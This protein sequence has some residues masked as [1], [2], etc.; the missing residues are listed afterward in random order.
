[1][2]TDSS[3]RPA[4]IKLPADGPKFPFLVTDESVQSSS[5]I[6]IGLADRFP[7]E[8]EMTNGETQLF[9][10]AGGEITKRDRGGSAPEYVV[11]Q[12]HSFARDDENDRSYVSNFH[13]KSLQL[14]SAYG[15]TMVYSAWLTKAQF[16]PEGFQMA[17]YDEFNPF[18]GAVKMNDENDHYAN[19]G[20]P[21]TP[22]QVRFENLTFPIEVEVTLHYNL[23]DADAKLTEHVAACHAARVV[24]EQ[25]A[26]KRAAEVERKRAARLEARKAYLLT[27]E[28][29]AETAETELL[30]TVRAIPEGDSWTK[31]SLAV[32]RGEAAE[33]VAK[34]SDGV[35][36]ELKSERA[37][38]TWGIN[39]SNTGRVAYKNAFVEAVDNR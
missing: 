6:T 7:E 21:Y 27:D 19:S 15:R 24:R 18:K 10:I 5:Y 12:R 35:V 13:L 30:K 29:K 3:T 28:G 20:Y 8:P 2:T 32:I 4:S 17:P 25:E 39:L 34:L 14:V 11:E 31:R 16:Y 9:F 38:E 37:W 33:A 26:A 1:M 22:P 36:A 23:T